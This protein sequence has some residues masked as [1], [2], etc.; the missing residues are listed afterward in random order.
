MSTAGVRTHRHENQHNRVNVFPTDAHSPVAPL[1]ELNNLEDNSASDL[2]MATRA[3]STCEQDI[4]NE[5]KTQNKPRLTIRQ[6]REAAQKEN[7]AKETAKAQQKRTESQQKTSNAPK[8]KKQSVLGGLFQVR[9]PTQIALEQVAAQMIAQHG[10]TSATKVPNVRLEKMPEF[11]PK[12]NSKWD[13]IPENMKQKA[14]KDKDN[15]KDQDKQRAQRDSFFSL[16]AKSGSDEDKRRGNSRNSHSTSGSSFGAYGSSNGSQ[17]A[18]SRIRFY[19]HSVNSS[20]DLASQQR[21]SAS[22]FSRSPGSLRTV[23]STDFPLHAPAHVRRRSR[24]AG[25]QRQVQARESLKVDSPV[26]GAR[27]LSPVRRQKS[28][29]SYSTSGSWRLPSRGSANHRTEARA[30]VI[31]SRDS[32]Q[33]PISP[34][35]RGTSDVG[36]IPSYPSSPRNPQETKLIHPPAFESPIT[37]QATEMANLETPSAGDK[38]VQLQSPPSKNPQVPRSGAFLAGEAQ[39]LVL[40]DRTE[41]E[42]PFLATEP[43]SRMTESRQSR[44]QQD[45]EKRPDSS[46]DRLGLRASMLFI[47]ESTPWQ[48]PETEQAPLPSPKLPPPISSTMTRFHKTFGKIAK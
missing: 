11:V 28:T 13:G 9:E 6:L 4:E 5:V 15:N 3:D 26:P 34:G 20:G 12:V 8:K 25:P 10:S 42:N 45:L 33:S 23:D 37:G 21:T 46:R 18:S 36:S 47:D 27:E 31:Q 29:N 22:N 16:E 38:S 35:F 39:E 2:V 40:E 43:D 32:V 14:K 19:A 48:G 30:S 7:S 41:H 24:S 1:H 17:G 44:L